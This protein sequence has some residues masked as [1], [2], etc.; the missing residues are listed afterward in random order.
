[1]AKFCNWPQHPVELEPIQGPASGAFVLAGWSR[2]WL[3]GMS[4]VEM[5]RH[6]GSKKLTLS[7]L[8]TSRP[9]PNLAVVTRVAIKTGGQLK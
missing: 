2:P 6:P 5:I 9:K 3:I 1:M 8:A 7:V 4:L